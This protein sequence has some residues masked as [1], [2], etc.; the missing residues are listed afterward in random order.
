M[1]KVCLY[2]MLILWLWEKVLDQNQL[3]KIHAIIYSFWLVLI[4]EYA[5]LFPQVL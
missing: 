2:T 4:Y 1:C 3:T 5:W